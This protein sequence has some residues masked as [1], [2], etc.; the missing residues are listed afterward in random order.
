MYEKMLHKNLVS[1]LDTNNIKK[2]PIC[3]S[4]FPHLWLQIDFIAIWYIK[5]T[6]DNTFVTFLLT[7]KTYN[8]AGQTQT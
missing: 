4:S 1:F 2:S 7:K 6:L 5:M 3:F 8:I